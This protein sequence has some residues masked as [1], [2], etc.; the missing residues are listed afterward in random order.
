M[1]D[2]N[3]IQSIL[4]FIPM[5]H[6]L[7]LQELNSK[8]Y[9]VIKKSKEGLMKEK[10]KLFQSACYEGRFEIAKWIFSEAVEESHFKGVI[11]NLD[12]N[13]AFNMACFLGHIEI[14]KWMRSKG[15]LNLKQGFSRACAGGHFEVSKYL[16]EEGKKNDDKSTKPN[17]NEGCYWAY[18]NDHIE[19]G[20]YLE[21]K[22]A[23]KYFRE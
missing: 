5:S 9:H 20:E 6:L 2:Q 19:L 4:S 8:F 15:I 3:L 7:Q 12:L 17:L 10:N 1:I 18:R 11:L 13:S 22:G 23:V 21:A 16:I 14:V